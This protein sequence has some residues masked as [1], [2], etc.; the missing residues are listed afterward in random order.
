MS[1]HNWIENAGEQGL[2]FTATHAQ[3]LEALDI[4][5]ETCPETLFQDVYFD[6]AKWLRH[7]TRAGAVGTVGS[8]GSEDLEDIQF[9]GRIDVLSKDSYMVVNIVD[10]EFDPKQMFQGLPVKDW[11]YG[12][13]PKATP[14]GETVVIIDSDTLG[15]GHFL[16]S[17]IS[18]E[19]PSQLKPKS[20][21]GLNLE[22]FFGGDEG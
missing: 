12:V 5:P 4:L 17:W 6:E 22:D 18:T 1:E 15:V 7:A 19:A 11:L 9:L 20:D 2:E 8:V 3:I 13:D 16:E 10:G 21:D 14:E